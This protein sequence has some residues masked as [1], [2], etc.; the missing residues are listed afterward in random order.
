[1][2]IE[3]VI[4]L[5]VAPLLL[6][7]SREVWQGLW[8]MPLLTAFGLIA[9][10]VDSTFALLTA[11]FIS[12]YYYQR[13]PSGASRFPEFSYSYWLLAG[14]SGSLL[15]DTAIHPLFYS[16]L[17]FLVTILSADLSARLLQFKRN[18]LEKIISAGWYKSKNN[19][20]FSMVLS[21]LLS[22]T[23]FFIPGLVLYLCIE[24]IKFLDLGFIF[25]YGLAK[26]ITTFLTAT[27][28]LVQIKN[29]VRKVNRPKIL[30]FILGFST[31]LLL[32]FS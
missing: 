20:L 5:L 17:I 18:L 21:L 31:V 8:S 10:G 13:T 11:L 30:V 14:L 25:G 19:L 16:E 4:I 24:F 3:V 7:E 29:S 28:L 15:K 27:V 12:L 1:M 23:L 2:P 9:L 32:N 22:F 26:L 6:V